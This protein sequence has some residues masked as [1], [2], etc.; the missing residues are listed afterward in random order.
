MVDSLL[1]DLTTIS[2]RLVLTLCC[3]LT[4]LSNSLSL[5]PGQTGGRKQS[6]AA[7]FSTLIG[8]E[9]LMFCCDWFGWIF[10]ILCISPPVLLCLEEP[11]QGKKCVPWV[12]IWELV[13]QLYE[14][15]WPMRAKHCWTSTNQSEKQARLKSEYDRQQL[16][17]QD[18]D[19]V[20]RPG[21][22]PCSSEPVYDLYDGA[23]IWPQGTDKKFNR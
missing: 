17:L 16:E 14:P 5:S 7:V 15:S 8:R 22:I 13:E 6:P 9:L 1:L 12:G 23:E 20:K 10:L 11:T 3:I 18:E 19:R 2:L 4:W 21:G